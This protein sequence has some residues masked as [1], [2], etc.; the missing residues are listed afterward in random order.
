MSLPLELREQIYEEI[1]SS[2]TVRHG[3][4]TSSSNRTAL[5]RT[6]KQIYNESWRH[7]PLNIRFHFRGTETMLETLLGADQAVITRIRYVRIKSFPFPLYNSGRADYYPTYYFHN[8]LSMLPG[9]HLDQLIVEDCFHGYGL[10]DTWRDIV[11]YFDV[12]SLIKSEAWK[13]L[14]YITPNTDFIV[15]GYDH[16]R[17]RVAQPDSWDELLKEKDGETSGAEVEMWITP[18]SSKNYTQKE[19]QPRS[20]SAKPGHEVINDWTIAGPDQ[21]L[22]G[23]VRIVARRGKQANIIQTGLSEAKTWK[24]LKNKEGGFDR[25]GECMIS[26]LAVHML[27][28]MTDWRPYY[29]DMADAVGWIYGGWGRRMELANAALS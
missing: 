22:K 23:E 5:I 29:N 9:L 28:C 1:F 25:S 7:L 27:M 12:E 18:E 20:W 21:E 26:N 16:R 8:A 14:I 10:V 24:E 19:P 6:C 2:F 13:E 15:S 17:K 11:T 4:H 3:F